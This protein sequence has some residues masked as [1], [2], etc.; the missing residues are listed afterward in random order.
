M[1]RSVWFF[2]DGDRA[3]GPVS[4]DA[5]LAAARRNE[6]TRAGR[7]WTPAVDGWI[8]ASD[9][10]WLFGEAGSGA[11]PPTAAEGAMAVPPP[12]KGT[13]FAR[14]R[15]ASP[16]KRLGLVPAEPWRRAVGLLIDAGVVILLTLLIGGSFYWALQQ[17]G[18]NGPDV[19]QSD[20]MSLTTVVILLLYH[21]AAESYWGTS[22]G[23]ALMRCRV[24]DAFGE[25][26][27]ATRIVARAFFR[28]VT[29]IGVMVGAMV[30]LDGRVSSSNRPW[31][32]STAPL[33]IFTM[34]SVWV[35]DRRALH[36]LAGGTWV[37]RVAT[38]ASAEAR[39]ADTR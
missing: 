14:S 22:A 5:L 32:F 3:A 25:T 11:V 17:W 33:V 13:V 36:D 37:V 21:V 35:R 1:S 9:V 26:P 27:F 28:G 8:S 10:P 18:L 30:L 20:I 16:I 39:L 4:W 6:L 38:G 29:V 2:A 19:E 34:V 31:V 24:V 23:K 15:P 7:V 12:L